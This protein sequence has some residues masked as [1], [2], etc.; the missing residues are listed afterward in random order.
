VQG[1]PLFGGRRCRLRPTWWHLSRRWHCLPCGARGGGPTALVFK[2]KG[3]PMCCNRPQV[4]RIESSRLQPARRLA[5]TGRHTFV[6]VSPFCCIRCARLEVVA[7][8]GSSGWSKNTAF[9]FLIPL[10][11]VILAVARLWMTRDPQK[12]PLKVVLSLP[13]R[14]CRLG[15]ARRDS[16]QFVVSAFLLPSAFALF[17]CTSRVEDGKGVNVRYHCAKILAALLPC[18]WPGSS[19]STGTRTAGE[20]G[21]AA[22]PSAVAGRRPSLSPAVFGLFRCAPHQH[23]QIS[24]Q[25]TVVSVTCLLITIFD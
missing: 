8:G 12:A 24:L 20:G 3:W 18:F 6:K 7:F 9:F 5:V 17:S 16:T 2:G 14:G 1:V 21:R 23:A 11:A 15:I 25:D 22:E 13:R 10:P 19:S 4:S